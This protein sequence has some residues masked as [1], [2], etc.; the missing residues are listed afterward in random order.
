MIE[1]SLARLID[2]GGV[3]ML[4]LFS[5]VAIG[6]LWR[7]VDQAKK[8]GELRYESLNYK[9]DIL[10]NKYELVL[11]EMG[12]MH[13]KVDTEVNIDAKLTIIIEEM[14]K[15]RTRTRKGDNQN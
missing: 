12:K 13:G 4:A 7:E 1:N 9:Y 14:Q 5:L 6:F 2:Y 10:Q 11:T 15:T 3:G 8:A